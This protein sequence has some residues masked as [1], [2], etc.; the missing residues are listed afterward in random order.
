M[1]D[2]TSADVWKAIER[3]NFMVVGMVSAKGEARTA[4][5]MHVVH[6]GV[7]WFT[8]NEREHKARHLAANPGVSVTVPIPKRIPFMPKVKIPAASVTFS[9][10][11]EIVPTTPP[12]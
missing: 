3:V 5:V 1:A 7:L 6:E 2:I 8:T 11:A 12:P 4:G 10:V 9:G